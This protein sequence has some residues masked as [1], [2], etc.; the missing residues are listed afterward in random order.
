M[1]NTEKDLG[2][3]EWFESYQK[4]NRGKECLG[5][6]KLFIILSASVA[7]LVP[8]ANAFG[9]LTPAIKNNLLDFSGLL[10]FISILFLEKALGLEISASGFHGA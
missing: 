8:L 10:L 3:H 2:L 4:K 1:K 6:A 5:K 7:A 9:V